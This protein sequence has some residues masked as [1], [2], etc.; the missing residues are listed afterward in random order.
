MGQKW[1]D[2]KRMMIVA[3]ME[4]GTSVRWEVPVPLVKIQLSESV[5]TRKHKVITNCI[6]KQYTSIKIKKYSLNIFFK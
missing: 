2:R 1:N 4:G 3:L 6:V 5:E